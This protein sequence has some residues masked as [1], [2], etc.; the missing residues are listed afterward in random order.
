[1]STER[2]TSMHIFAVCGLTIVD[3]KFSIGWTPFHL[4]A[5]SA[6]MQ[7]KRNAKGKHALGPL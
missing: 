6:V 7:F 4:P 3:A 2:E 5:L 1:M